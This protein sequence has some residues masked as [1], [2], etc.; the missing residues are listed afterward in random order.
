M[1]KKPKAKN[2][3][4]MT[5]ILVTRFQMGQITAKDLELMAKDLSKAKRASAAEK[6]LAGI[7]GA[8]DLV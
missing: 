7:K 4:V 1:A 8:G 6:V 5:G 3:A 2:D